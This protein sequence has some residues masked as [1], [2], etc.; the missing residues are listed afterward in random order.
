MSRVNIVYKRRPSQGGKVNYDLT[1]LV[2][3]NNIREEYKKAL[4]EIDLDCDPNDALT[5]VLKCVENVNACSKHHWRDQKQEQ[6]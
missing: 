3:S 4:D 5:E 1:K 2:N 6:I